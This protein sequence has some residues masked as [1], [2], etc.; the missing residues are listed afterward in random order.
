MLWYLH[1]TARLLMQVYA[2]TIVAWEYYTLISV[3]IS[4]TS[5]Y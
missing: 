5:F 3:A 4:I 2:Y 1:V